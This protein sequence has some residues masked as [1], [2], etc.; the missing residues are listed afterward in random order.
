MEEF[1]RVERELEGR[2]A[3]REPDANR[4][5]P[6]MGPGVAMR[7][8]FWHGGQNRKGHDVKFCIS[9]YV[10]V[11]GYFLIWVQVER[12]VTKRGYVTERMDWSC[13]KNPATAK[14]KMIA[15]ANGFCARQGKA[16]MFNAD[17]V[18]IN[19]YGLFS[20]GD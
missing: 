18:F 8:R 2:K 7:Y 15:K 1:E 9:N 17:G 16:P 6:I 4:L 12:Y 5:T 10:N 20:S 11:A 14:K 3:R 13:S 19:N